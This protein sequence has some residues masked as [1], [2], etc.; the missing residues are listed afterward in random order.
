MCCETVQ[1]IQFDHQYGTTFH[2]KAFVLH[3][4]LSLLNIDY[5]ILQGESAAITV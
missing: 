4:I 1:I 3:S 5:Q 2:S